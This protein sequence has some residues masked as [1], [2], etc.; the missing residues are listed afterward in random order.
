MPQGT[1]IE[2]VHANLLEVE[3][4]QGN[5]DKKVFNFFFRGAL[6]GDRGPRQAFI[7][8]FYQKFYEACLE[9]GIQPVWDEDNEAKIAAV[10]HRLNFNEP[11]T[12]PEPRPRPTKPRTKRTATPLDKSVL[13]P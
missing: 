9:S 3:R 5:I 4:V 11:R 8:Y 12:E 6:V 10:L 13:A 2:N 1:N 7:T